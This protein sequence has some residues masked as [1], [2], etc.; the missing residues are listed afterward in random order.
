MNKKEFL[1]KEK[2]INQSN[3]DVM[4]AI[5][6]NSKGYIDFGEAYFSKVKYNS[7]KA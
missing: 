2:I 5:K 6:K 7:V 3:G 4:H 1:S